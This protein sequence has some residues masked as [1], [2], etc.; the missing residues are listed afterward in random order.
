MLEAAGDVASEKLDKCGAKDAF[1]AKQL[2]DDTESIDMSCAGI[3]GPDE[4]VVKKTE[5]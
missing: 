4:C 3:T 5:E 1:A 2:E